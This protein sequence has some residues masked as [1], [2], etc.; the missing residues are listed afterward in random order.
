VEYF[1]RTGGDSLVVEWKGPG[2]ERQQIAQGLLS[3]ST[4]IESTDTNTDNDDDST[5][6]GGSE[7]DSTGDSGDSN[8]A[9]SNEL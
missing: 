6:P 8:T 4:D 9:A 1:E 5:D 3:A 2:I 7:G